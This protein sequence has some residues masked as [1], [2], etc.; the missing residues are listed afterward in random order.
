[1]GELYL[2]T[3]CR[4]ANALVRV[5]CELVEG[6]EPSCADRLSNFVSGLLRFVNRFGRSML[7]GR[8]LA[9]SLALQP[10][11]ATPGLFRRRDNEKENTGFPEKKKKP[12]YQKKKKKKK[13]K[14]K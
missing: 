7:F 8:A 13:K 3:G 1:M 12:A 10:S 4:Q 14:K 2:K 5:I 11:I 9:T 6:P